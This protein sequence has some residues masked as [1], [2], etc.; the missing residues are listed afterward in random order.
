[1]MLPSGNDASL[2]LALWAGEKLF[3]FQ[4]KVKKLSGK[5]SSRAKTTISQQSTMAT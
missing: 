2:A 4:K 1:M 5:A 3:H